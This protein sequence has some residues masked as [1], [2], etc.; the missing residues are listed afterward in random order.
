[1]YS[2]P[3]HSRDSL[4]S[5][6][7]QPPSPSG[8]ANLHAPPTAFRRSSVPQHMYT[9]GYVPT[10][11]QTHSR[12]SSV[13]D[14]AADLLGPNGPEQLAKIRQTGSKIEDLIDQYSRPLRPWLPGL[15]R[16][17][18]IVTF[19]EDA[20]RILTQISDQN[21]YLQKHRGFPWGLSHIFLYG[22]VMVMLA[23]STL[24]MAKRFPE[25]ATGGLFLVVIAQGLGYGLIFDLNFFLRNLSVIGGLLMVLS[26]SLSTRKSVFA[27]IPSLD[28]ND[29][30][31]KK[32]F[33][34]AGRVLLVFLFMGFVFNGK[35]TASRAF[36]SVVGIAACLMVA[37]GYKAKVSALFLVTTLCIFNFTINNFWAVHSAHPQRDFL[38]YDFF[39]TLSIVGGLL[40][41]VNLGAGELSVDSGKKML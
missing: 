37:I 17:L 39:Q 32:Y 27:G 5:I 12:R 23:C 24:V 1:M 33:Q 7:I 9:Q 15:G 20:L 41:L 8:S 10:P 11:G 21:Y 22:N 38:K 35:L 36:V 13:V 6:G 30:D 25:I 40:L 31:R 4:P 18:I 26:D 3:N 2:S 14:I 16:F 34:L 28:L 29:T 19:L